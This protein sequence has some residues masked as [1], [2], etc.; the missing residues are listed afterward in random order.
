MNEVTETIYQWCKGMK[1]QHISRSLGLDRKTIR[2]YLGIARRAGI[3]REGPPPDEHDIAARVRGIMDSQGSAYD[4]P[5]TDLLVRHR[6]DIKR[7]LD[8]RNM[9]GKQVWRL[10]KETY[11]IEVGYTTIKR[12]LRREFSFGR[13]SVTVRMETPAG[14]EAQVDFGYAGLMHDPEVQKNRRAWAFI[15]TLSASRHKFVRFVFRQD[16]GTWLDCHERAFAFFGGVPKRIIL[17]NLKSGVVKADIYD[18][19]INRAYADMERHYGFVA[20]PARVRAPEH[21]GKVER[22]VPTVRKHLLAGRTFGDITEANDRALYWCREEIG[23]EIHGTTKKT[24]RVLLEGGEASSHP[25]SGDPLRVS[26]MEGVYC[27]SGSSYRLRQILLLAANALH[28]Q[29]GMGKGDRKNSG[30]LSRPRAGQGPSTGPRAGT[31]GDGPKRLPAGQARLPHGDTNMVQEEGI[32]VRPCYGGLRNSDPERERHKEPEE[33]PG[34]TA[35]CREE[36]RR[37]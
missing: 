1:I 22:A 33:G 21:K 34:H 29:K 19:T 18:P 27:S 30:G 31:V 17:D 5:A 9:T 25:P 23:I 16:T 7:W 11:G 37:H 12:Y 15:M 36:L 4:T 24:L 6:D 3:E 32:R 26:P 2:K 10:L 20:D 13:P 14:E 8:D 35:P 28:R